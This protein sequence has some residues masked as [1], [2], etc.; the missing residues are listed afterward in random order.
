[1]NAGG[2][3]IM[4]LS[5]AVLGI[6][7]I[8]ITLGAEVLVR[9]ASALALRMGVSPLFIGLTIV[10]FGTSSPEL[11]AS[12]A[13]VAR[14]SPDIAVGNVVGSNIF[15]IA[16]ILGL[17]AAVRP[18]V[19]GIA[20]IRRDI[21]IVILVAAVPWLAVAAGSVLP[22]WSGVV[23]VAALL[24]YIWISYLAGRKAAPDVQREIE[25][26]IEES[27]LIA[28]DP[29]SPS[30]SVPCPGVP[31]GEGRKKWWDRGWV[32]IVSVI[33]GLGLLVLG[34]RFF[35][36]AAV[37]IARAIGMSE[38][39]IGL[40]IVA[41]GT[42]MP[43]LM[44]STVA[45][46]RGRSDLAVGNILGSNIFNILGILGICAIVQPQAV[47]QQVLVLDTPVM[48]AASVALLPI[49][50]SGGRIARGEGIAM[51]VAY[52]GYVAV[53]LAAAPRW[54]GGG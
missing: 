4:L 45:A 46:I 35:V 1:V 22:R 21:F 30:L 40:T 7:L 19:I 6:S 27:L 52:A 18:I 49:I 47:S 26:G 20:A 36:D 38:L 53:L 14:G 43:E 23:M 11:G 12:L 8:T 28:H 48:F 42:S 13:A 54:F 44:T 34:S 2:S 24:A 51:M 31:E 15:N 10:A 37:E 25:S 41:A 9:G 17:A 5:I 39:A 29:Q 16:I 50:R 3:L 33:I 32:S